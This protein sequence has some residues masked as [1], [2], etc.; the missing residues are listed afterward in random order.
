MS[1]LI[2][3]LVVTTLIAVPLPDRV[4]GC[5]IAER[6]IFGGKSVDLAPDVNVRFHWGTQ[7]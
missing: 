2:T 1:M 6:V 4:R 7:L 5:R 3:V